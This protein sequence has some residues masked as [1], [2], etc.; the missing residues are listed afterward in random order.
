M[1]MGQRRKPVRR[2]P[3]WVAYAAVAAGVA[4]A[5]CRG[6]GPG[7]SGPGGSGPGVGEGAGGGE[8]LAGVVSRDLVGVHRVIEVRP[9]V[10]CGSMPEGQAGLRT[11]AGLGVRT[12]ISVDG[13]RP[14]VDGAASYGMA[15][16]HIPVEYG[17]ISTWERLA[18]ARAIGEARG[19]V[20]VHCHHGQHRGP[21]AAAVGLGALGLMAQEEALGL[22]ER[23]GTSRKYPGLWAAAGEAG[24]LSEAERAA[25]GGLELRAAAEV[26]G[27]V[28]KMADIDRRYGH[29]RALEAYGFGASAE[30]PDLV[31]LTEAAILADRLR[32]SLDE[33][34]YREGPAGFRAWLEEAARRG[35]ELEGAVEVGDGPG[36]RAALGHLGATCTGCHGEYRD[37]FARGGGGG[38]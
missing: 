17:G 37:A 10:L 7:G 31:P 20:Y 22:L 24:P 16:V 13:A 26:S 18:L 32:E 9:G 14:D 4:A 29:L 15:Y 34:E 12:I 30:H 28:A 6:D 3:R 35:A 19:V 38:G 23:A 1:A 11:L 33:P 36:A 5:S 2:G 21:T 8:L 25:M 27:F